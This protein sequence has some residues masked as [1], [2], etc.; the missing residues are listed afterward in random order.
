MRGIMTT[1]HAARLLAGA[2]LAALL[3]IQAQAESAPP[4]SAPPQTEAAPAADDA[5]ATSEGDILVTARRQSERLQD[6]PSAVTAFT[7]DALERRSV[8]TLDQIAKY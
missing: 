8:D 3:P 7:G 2:A 4:Q 1:R 6:V 5:A